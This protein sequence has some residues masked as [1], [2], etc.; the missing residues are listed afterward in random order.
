MY[1]K[2]R[3]FCNKINAFSSC[4]TWCLTESFVLRNRPTFHILTVGINA[5]TRGHSLSLKLPAYS[6]IP[7]FEASQAHLT[8]AP[9]R[10]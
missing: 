2:N 10:F 5:P 3:R 7:T 6:S 8:V 4:Q 9:P 1:I